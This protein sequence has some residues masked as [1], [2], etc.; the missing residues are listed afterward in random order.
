M[1][2]LRRNET[3]KWEIVGRDT[4]ESNLHFFLISTL[5]PYSLPREDCIKYYANPSVYEILTDLCETFFYLII[6]LCYC[7]ESPIT[8]QR[9]N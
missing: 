3:Y 1:N 9:E 6:A 5:L 8:I 4:Y 2:E 7:S